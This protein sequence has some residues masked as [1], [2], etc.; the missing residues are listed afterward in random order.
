MWQLSASPYNNYTK[1]A[2]WLNN[3][4]YWY[5][6]KAYSFGFSP[7]STISQGDGGYFDCGGRFYNCKDEKRLS[8]SVFNNDHSRLGKLTVREGTLNNYRKI[9]MLIE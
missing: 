9:L 1:S 5:L 4:A 7:I 6:T 8:W 2:G 3:G